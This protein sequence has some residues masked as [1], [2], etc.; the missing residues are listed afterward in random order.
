VR[1]VTDREVRR[2]V[3][4]PAVRSRDFL[5]SLPRLLVALRTGAMRYG[6]LVWDRP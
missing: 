4:S 5:L 2:L 6:V 1:L 3:T